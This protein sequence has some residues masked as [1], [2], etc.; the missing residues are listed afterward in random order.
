MKLDNKFIVG[1]NSCFLF[2]VYTICS[3][4]N[5]WLN[6]GNFI[7]FPFMKKLLNTSWAS[8]L[9]LVSALLVYNRIQNFLTFTVIIKILLT[10]YLR[11]QFT[12]LNFEIIC[13]QEIKTILI[14]YE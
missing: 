8:L 6:F 11:W 2:P 5:E 1:N 3:S 4:K 9:L 12:S 7:I 14:V 13:W 10:V